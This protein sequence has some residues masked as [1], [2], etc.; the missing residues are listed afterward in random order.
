MKCANRADVFR[1]AVA[2]AFLTI[3]L[4]PFNSAWAEPTDTQQPDSIASLTLKDGT[5]TYYATLQEAFDDAPTT[6][7]G[8]APA[9]IKLLDNVVENIERAKGGTIYFD[10]NGCSLTNKDS[11]PTILRDA[12]STSVLTI[13]DSSGSGGA[14][15]NTTNSFAAIVA[16]A[17]ITFENGVKVQ[18]GKYNVQALGYPQ[19][20]RSKITAY[21]ATFEGA[22]EAAFYL[23]PRADLSSTSNKT[24]CYLY[25]ATVITDGIGIIAN[26]GA[27]ISCS[28]DNGKYSGPTFTCGSSILK[29][30]D[31]PNSTITIYNGFYSVTGEAEVFD[32]Y[33]GAAD[34][35]IQ[36]SAYN[37]GPLS[38]NKTFDE[39]YFTKGSE[40]EF[41][42][43]DDN[44]V[45]AVSVS[46]QVEV[47]HAD[48]TTETINGLA[49]ALSKAKEGDTLKLLPKT[50]GGENK[51]ITADSTYAVKQSITLD[52]NG[53]TLSSSSASTVL[54]VSGSAKV[55]IKN[56]SITSDCQPEESKVVNTSLY[57]H[58]CAEVVLEDM[59]V[60]ATGGTHARGV[61]LGT[62]FKPNSATPTD[63]TGGPTLT[64]MGNTTIYG[65]QMGIFMAAHSSVNGKEDGTPTTLNA[66]AGSVTGGLYGIGSYHINH[67][68]AINV[69]GASVSATNGVGIFAPQNA[70]VNI[71]DGSVTGNVGIQMSGPGSLNI[72]GG[73]VTGTGSKTDLPGSIT[74]ALN[75]VDGYYNDGAAVSL[76]QRSFTSGGVIDL[77]S[78]S[79]LEVSLMGGT[80]TSNNNAALREYTKVNTV[81]DSLVKSMNIGGNATFMSASSAGSDLEFGALTGNSAK[82]VEG[83]SFSHQ[84]SEDYCIDGYQSIPDPNNPGSFIIVPL[85]DPDPDNPDSNPDNPDLVDPDTDDPT[86]PTTPD[87]TNPDGND[88]DPNNPDASTSDSANLGTD[89][90][91]A[92]GNSQESVALGERIAALGDSLGGMLAVI[93]AAAC[94]SAILVVVS[95]CS[96]WSS[97]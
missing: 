14:I 22:L 7:N 61:W 62:N 56:G 44:G 9:T 82:V 50:T 76:V 15:I 84:V 40:N 25:D 27:A 68:T 31:K 91:N 90:S 32:V 29:V 58:D 24:Y 30:L 39:K 37:G 3:F 66:N 74:G 88:S 46:T 77:G 96:R 69:N 70:V 65:D 83:G 64:I 21:S 41:V 11:G 10:L 12:N 93:F 81:D 73:S 63:T 4:F 36:V 17:P 26:E 53:F 47:T 23:D 71:T 51:T 59:S 80:L 72:T 95:A 38:F 1:L 57:I 48:G 8:G 54:S 85:E 45:Y 28:N 86:K 13:T 19:N 35:I 20:S 18:G 94:A 5:T 49:R 89:D 6:N 2:I 52:L 42:G 43:P 87:P 75:G 55:T 33:A 16:G 78:P 34:G 67:G 92:A 60:S 97:R 79:A